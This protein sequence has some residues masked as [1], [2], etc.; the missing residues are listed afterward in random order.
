MLILIS[1]AALC[2][3]VGPTTLPARAHVYVIYD[4][5]SQQMSNNGR[6]FGGVDETARWIIAAATHRVASLGWVL[7]ARGEGRCSE[8]HPLNHGLGGGTA[9][10][11]RKQN[12]RPISHLFYLS[13]SERV[14]QFF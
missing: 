14:K 9:H 7:G 5:R 11:S 13:G 8:L 1:R 4:V 6:P 10:G 3:S 2:S 12:A